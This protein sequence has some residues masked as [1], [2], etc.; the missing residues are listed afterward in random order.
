LNIV[1]SADLCPVWRLSDILSWY[2]WN[3]N[4]DAMI[5]IKRSNTQTSIKE[6]NTDLNSG[7]FA[8]PDVSEVVFIVV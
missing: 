5:S 3:T 4:D 2:L 7:L 8:L 1:P 6:N